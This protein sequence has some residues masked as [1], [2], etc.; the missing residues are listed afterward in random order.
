[1]FKNLGAMG[2]MAK[3]MKAAKDMQSKVAELQEEMDNMTVTGEAGAG[4]VKAT[5]NAK[6]KVK[7]LDI[8]PSID[9]PARGFSGSHLAGS[10]LPLGHTHRRGALLS[11]P[12]QG[13]SDVDRVNNQNIRFSHV[14]HHAGRCDFIGPL[15][16]LLLHL[17]CALVV[18]V[19]VLDLLVGHLVFVQERVSLDGEIDAAKQHKNQRADRSTSSG[20]RHMWAAISP[21]LTMWDCCTGF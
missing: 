10:I 15:A 16:P 5:A 20:A 14:L 21:L 4:L 8:D 17:G 1:M 9:P 2:D 7:A 6:G 12:A 3:M 18:F 11:G 13:N 19:L